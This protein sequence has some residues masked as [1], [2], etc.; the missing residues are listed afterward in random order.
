MRFFANFEIHH[1]TSTVIG[2]YYEFLKQIKTLVSEGRNIK[3]VVW[4][5][6]FKLKKDTDINQVY[7]PCILCFNI[8]TTGL[9]FTNISAVKKV[10]AA[11][12]LIMVRGPE[13]L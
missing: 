1:E 7:V 4:T 2:T 11:C 5:D 6:K 8:R 9:L 10:A 13:K 12:T 3:G